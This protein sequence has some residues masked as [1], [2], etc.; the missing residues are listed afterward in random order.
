ML[1]A[2]EEQL[3]SDVPLGSFLSGGIDST[4]I[5]ALSNKIYKK[6]STFTIG[7]NKK[8]LMKD[9]CKKNCRTFKNQSLSKIF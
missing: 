3:I 6:I 1:E 7:F 9:I 2:V 5:T 8:N 4:L